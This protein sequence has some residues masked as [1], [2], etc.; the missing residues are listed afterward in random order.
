[1]SKLAETSNSILGVSTRDANGNIKAQSVLFGELLDRIAEIP[2]P[3]ERMAASMKIFGMSGREVFNIASQGKE[4]IHELMQET[5]KYGLVLDK[6]IL[7]QLHDAEEAQ[8]R[9]NMQL[10]VASAQMSIS[11][12]PA[13]NAMLPALVKLVNVLSDTITFDAKILSGE[14]IIQAARDISIG[15]TIAQAKAEGDVNKMFELRQ[16]NLKKIAEY[17][18][19]IEG[20]KSRGE[21]SGNLSDKIAAL[22][23]ENL[24][25]GKAVKDINTPEKTASFGGDSDVEDYLRKQAKAAKSPIVY[26]KVNYEGNAQAKVLEGGENEGFTKDYIEQEKKYDE[27]DKKLEEEDKQREEQHRKWV[28][29]S[30]AWAHNELASFHEKQLKETE[31]H[32]KKMLMEY[33]EFG[34]KYGQSIGAAIGKGKEGQKEALQATLD[35]GIE[36]LEKLA[37]QAVAANALQDI[38][39][40]GFIYGAI[41]AAV[42]G[43]LIEG[44]ATAAKSQIGHMA[45][46]GVVTGG[47]PGVDSVPAVLMPGEIVYNPARPNPALANMITSSTTSGDTHVHIQGPTI[48]IAGSVDSKTVASV[49]QATAMATKTAVHQALRQLQ[50]D[51]KI[52][53]VTIRN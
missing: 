2:N 53:G 30:H 32:N 38:T 33:M 23:A 14:N 12:L 8:N 9:F 19:N 47:I 16:E 51:N 45:N 52:S 10:K 11:L 44:V 40:H 27:E 1:M 41:E 35:M 48:H 4:R 34:E 21:K 17:E 39:T 18:K 37:L 24:L 43:A 50:S 31:E 42:E 22:K 46:G 20:L 13:I 5:T 6:G 7:R 28:V 25:Y 3:T 15:K 49:S 36:F 29:E 26:D